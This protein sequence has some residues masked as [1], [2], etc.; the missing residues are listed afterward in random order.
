[1]VHNT[2]IITKYADE[3]QVVDDTTWSHAGYE[4]SGSGLT[5]KL[6]NK[7]VSCCRQTTIMT[8]S[9]RFRS[10]AIIY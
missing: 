10:R 8:E 6:M 7:K 3:H 9:C 1:M 5:G 2:N 4:E